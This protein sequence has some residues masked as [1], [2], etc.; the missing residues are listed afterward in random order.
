VPKATVDRQKFLPR[1]V[2]INPVAA[3]STFPARRDLACSNRAISTPVISSRP[4]R[5]RWISH[6]WE[7]HCRPR[8]SRYSWHIAISPAEAGRHFDPGDG[9][10]S[11][12]RALVIDACVE[13]PQRAALTSKAFP[14]INSLLGKPYCRA[15][16]G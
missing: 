12:S 7:I 8:R 11:I 2:K 14:C 15:Q 16:A 10:L 9:L 4:A 13:L 6:A 1:A 3:R 5:Q